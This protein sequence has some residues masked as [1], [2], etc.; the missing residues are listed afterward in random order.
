MRTKRLSPLDASWLYVESHQTP[1]HVGGLM[2]FELAPDAAPDFFQQL[3]NDFREHREFHPPWNRRLKSTR[4]K[5]LTPAWVEDQDLDLDYHLRLSAL[6][7]PGGERELG[8]LIARL[9]SHPLDFRRPPWECHVIQGL[10][11]H[12]FALYVKMHHSLID[13]VS[14]MRELVRVLSRDPDDGERPPFWAVPREKRTEKDLARVPTTEAAV[15]KALAAVPKQPGSAPTLIKALTE[16][17]KASRRKDDPMGVPFKA[18]KSILNGRITGQRRFATQSYSIDRLKRLAKA[19][20]ETVLAHQGARASAAASARPDAGTPP[21]EATLN[22]VVLAI[23]G[24]A[25]RRFLQEANALPAT[26]LTAGIP[27]SVRPKDDQDAGNA[28]SFIIATLGTDIADPVLRLQAITAS[29]RRSKEHLQSLPKSVIEGYTMAIMGPYMIQLV[30]GLGGRTRPVFN[31]TISNVPG[32]DHALYLRGARMV[33][34]YPV[35]LITHGQALNITCNGY[36]GLLN[37]GFIGCRDSLP[38][39]Q[40]IAVYAGEALD[41]LEAAVTRSGRDRRRRAETA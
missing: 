21:G 22:D 38:H 23:C 14:A 25:L 30:T 32:P 2:I 34:N 8:V 12:R 5:A 13:G 16:L 33:A 26:S 29:T 27:V 41:E 20:S 19:A 6:P 40:R 28:I 10:E 11:N 9:H 39:M 3:V 31:I 37:F 15:G 36:A 35:S 18:P 24:G 4:L 1:M 7:W 17:V